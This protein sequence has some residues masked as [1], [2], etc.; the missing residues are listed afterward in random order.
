MFGR[1][2]TSC[3]S[4][5]SHEMF[6]AD[7]RWSWILSAKQSTSQKKPSGC[8]SKLNRRGYAGFG[9]CFHLPGFHFGTGFLSHS[10]VNSPKVESLASGL[11]P[12]FGLGREAP[13]ASFSAEGMRR[14]YVPNRQKSHPKLGPPA[15]CQL[16]YR[17]FFWEG[18]PA[19]LYRKRK[20]TRV[21]LF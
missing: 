14:V 10:Q 6:L 2:Q 3:H 21:P 8:G 20:K 9:P 12:S 16:F 7:L 4:I 5:L 15:R 11:H 18:S 13:R 1:S 17:F 19:K